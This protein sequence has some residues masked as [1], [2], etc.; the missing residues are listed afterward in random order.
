MTDEEFSALINE[1][2]SLKW[3]LR[4]MTRSIEEIQRIL[5]RVDEIDRQLGV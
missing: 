3:R 1:K 2:Q 4:E 5:N